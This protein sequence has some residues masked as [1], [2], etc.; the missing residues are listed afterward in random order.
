MMK[1][2]FV[3]LLV[4]GGASVLSSGASASS[5]F[6]LLVGT[7]TDTGSKGIYRYAF[8]SATGQIDASPQQVAISENPS[9]LTISAGQKYLYAVNENGPGG[10]D[11]VGKVSSFRID[12]F[13][14]E[15]LPINQVPTDG[16]EPTFSSLAKG[17]HHLFIANYAVQPVP[18]GSLAVVSVGSD[19]VLSPVV[20]QQAHAASKVN[21][22]RQ[23]SSHVHSVVSS[24]DGNFV[25]VQDLGADKVFI[26]NYDASN[27][28]HPLTPA[29]PASVA[30]PPGSGPRHLLFA[31]DGRHAYLTLE[32]S[33]A[34]VVFDVK[35]G[36]LV[37]KQL[38]ELAKGG[39]AAHKAGAA[40]H[41]SA[42]GKFLYVTNRGQASEL[43]VFS[44][45]ATSGT[46]QEVQRRSVEGVEPREFTFDPDGNFV[47]V[48]NQKSNQLVVM[49][50]D[51][52]SGKIGATVQ[53][54]N[55]ASPSDVKFLR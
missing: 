14:H 8:D 54:L 9:W 25:Y 11:V 21:P 38:I 34:V 20:E 30:L 3:P 1:R 16:E 42:D 22:Q 15:L 28:T 35:A 7:Y 26:Y 37:R 29:S 40:L 51:P 32:M 48:A 36:N 31:A 13:T 5:M 18:G 17:E 4:A 33:G 43:L 47:V 41:F 12:P 46:L 23:A 2:F 45:D 52:Q 10:P 39:D 49:A 55:I 19:G 24:P 53:K 44:V 27:V 6:D 50:R